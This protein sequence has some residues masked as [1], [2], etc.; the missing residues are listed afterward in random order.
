MQFNSNEEKIPMWTNKEKKKKE[1]RK[2]PNVDEKKIYIL[3]DPNVDKLDKNSK[4]F[5][6]S[7]E[8]EEI[9]ENHWIVRKMKKS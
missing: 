8:E 6:I 1:R 2:D 3:K 4:K 7:I 5:V 9:Y